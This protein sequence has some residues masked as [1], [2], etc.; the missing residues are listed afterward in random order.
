MLRQQREQFLKEQEEFI[1]MKQQQE[2]QQPPPPAKPQTELSIIT[3][4]TYQTPH[5]TPHQ[6]QLTAPQHAAHQQRDVSP[7]SRMEMQQNQ[8]QRPQ[9]PA[10]ARERSPNSAYA[11]VPFHPQ[12]PY[13]DSHELSQSARNNSSSHMT[14]TSYV[15]SSAPVHTYQNTSNVSTVVHHTVP[16]Y[17]QVQPTPSWQPDRR[18]AVSPNNSSRDAPA[19][20]PYRDGR[21]SRDAG[22]GPANAPSRD[23]GPSYVS[24]R[25]LHPAN[26]PFREDRSTLVTSRDPGPA[27]GSM[28]GSNSQ[29]TARLNVEEDSGISRRFSRDEMLAMNRKATP[30][31][32][33]PTSPKDN[34]SVNDYSNTN[35]RDSHSRVDKV[36]INSVP[37]AK[38]RDDKEWYGSSPRKSNTKPEETQQKAYQPPWESA[39]EKPGAK[40]QLSGPQDHWLI[41]EAERRRM[42]ESEGRLTSNK[43]VNRNTSPS[44]HFSGPIKPATDSNNRWR[45]NNH[46]AEPERPNPSM[47]AAI[48]QTLLQK[49]ANARGPPS[50]NEQ[51]SYHGGNSN[52]LSPSG[53]DVYHN[54][55]DSG[56]YPP[57]PM[58]PYHSPHPQQYQQPH[59]SQS[60][61]KYFPS[62]IPPPSQAPPSPQ[63]PPP[64]ADSGREMSGMQACAHC[65]QELGKQSW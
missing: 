28:Y 19:S 61:S 59:S 9:Q 4:P 18:D 45:G 51:Q 43:P 34:Y 5:Q 6:S 64:P 38:L 21:S 41:Q 54:H 13:K 56:Y 14:S 55:G 62:Q 11:P 17:I 35:S 22:P 7:S 20:A 52:R 36:S 8:Y 24:S 47:P 50:P 58:P 33:S 1:K 60:Q 44:S 53:Q 65:G 26:M 27:N 48:R 30:L 16:S 29:E 3:Q 63:A 25:D 15:T 46:N 10:H 40:L 37:K 42:A 49:T 32:S 23:G 31:Q 2:Q 12:R 39:K 57:S